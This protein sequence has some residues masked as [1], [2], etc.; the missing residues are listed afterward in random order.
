MDWMDG[1]FDIISPNKLFLLNVAAHVKGL[2]I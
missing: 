2:V 1:T